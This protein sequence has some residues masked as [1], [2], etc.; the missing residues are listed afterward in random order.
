MPDKIKGS[1]LFHPLGEEVSRLMLGSLMFDPK[2]QCAPLS[3]A[4]D[5]CFS[6]IRNVRR[7]GGSSHDWNSQW[8]RGSL[9]NIVWDARL[10]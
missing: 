10:R 9:C 3:D 8:H 7:V 5:T 4:L 1:K 2:A 6:K